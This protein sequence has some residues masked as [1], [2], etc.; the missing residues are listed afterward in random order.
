MANSRKL[1]QVLKSL[2]QVKLD[3]WSPESLERIKAG[4]T[5]R[6]NHVIEKAARLVADLGFHQLEADLLAAFDRLMEKPVQADPGCAGKISIIEALN[7]LGILEEKPYLVGVRYVQLEP[8][9]GGKEDTA[10]QLR[11]LCALGLAR[12][13]HPDAL[14]ECAHLLADPEPIARLGAVSAIGYRK[15]PGAEPLLRY[16][17]LTGDPDPK[18]IYECFRVL[19]EIA[20]QESLSFVGEFLDDKSQIVGEAAALA[21]GESKLEGA[22]DMLQTWIERQIDSSQRKIGFTAIALLRSERSFDYLIEL[23]SEGTQ[24]EAI[25]AVSVLKIYQGDIQRWELVQETIEKRGDEEIKKGV[26]WG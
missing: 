14:I 15:L 23:V 3:P 19:L 26:H 1:K 12:L 2:D 10:A 13:N 4:L 7:D 6:S 24:T 16:K 18:V 8:V 11:A 22:F 17:A 5:H 25:S 20:P 21:L 9:Y